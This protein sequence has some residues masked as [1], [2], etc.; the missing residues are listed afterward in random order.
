MKLTRATRRATRGA[1]RTSSQEFL[2]NIADLRKHLLRSS[3]KK[4]RLE[5]SAKE[6]TFRTDRK[7]WWKQIGSWEW[8]Y[9][10]SA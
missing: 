5:A 7:G 10:E 6:I 1:T 9:P 4:F 3:W 2:P 8:Q